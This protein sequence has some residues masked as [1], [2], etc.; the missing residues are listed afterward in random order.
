MPSAFENIRIMIAP[1]HGRAPIARIAQTGFP[2]ALRQ[3]CT[4]AVMAAA[5]VFIVLMKRLDGEIDILR[6]RRLF[7][8]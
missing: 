4:Y 3:V 8:A 7:S 5:T 6:G 2:V 1:L